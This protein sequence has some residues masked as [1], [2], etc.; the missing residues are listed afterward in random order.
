M[1]KQIQTNAD[2]NVILYRSP[3][4]P[5][6]KTEERNRYRLLAAPPNKVPEWSA[7]KP[8][9]NLLQQPHTLQIS[10]QLPGGDDRPCSPNLHSRRSSRGQ[11]PEPKTLIVVSKKTGKDVPQWSS[12]PGSRPLQTVQVCLRQDTKLFTSEKKNGG[13][14]QR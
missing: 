6:R 10:V 12:S 1:H 4:S 8:P 14:V 3:H 2:A 13:G 11:K 5:K 9:G 7:L